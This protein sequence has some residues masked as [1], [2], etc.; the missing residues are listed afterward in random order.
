MRA[1]SWVGPHA[2]AVVTALAVLILISAVVEVL[3][4]RLLTL[5]VAATACR[6][7]ALHCL[8]STAPSHPTAPTRTTTS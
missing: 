6:A 1:R 4:K 5:L 3:A 8:P 2:G 7:S